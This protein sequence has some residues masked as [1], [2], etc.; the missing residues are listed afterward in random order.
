MNSVLEGLNTFI[1]FAL[2]LF[3]SM[4]IY[5]L[6][7]L[8]FPFLPKIGKSIATTKSNSKV[9]TLKTMNHLLPMQKGQMI[10]GVV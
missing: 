10:K 9:S 6:L 2:I 1:C 4:M 5:W 7:E 3:T 8:I